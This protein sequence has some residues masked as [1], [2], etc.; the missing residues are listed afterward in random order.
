MDSESKLC[1]FVVDDDS[2]A[3]HSLALALSERGYSVELFA[4]ASELLA[5]LEPNA[6]GCLVLDVKM[7]GLSG[8]ELQQTLRERA[9]GLPIVFVTGH[10]DIAMSVRAMR[11]GALDFIEKPFAIEQLV[12]Q[13]ESAFTR[14]RDR[15]ALV[16]RF[17]RLTGRE[18]DVMRAL[19]AGPED[20]S[21]KEL[22]RALGISHRTVEH[23]RASVMAK[24]GARSRAELIELV[25]RS[26]HGV[27]SP[28]LREKND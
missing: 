4:S 1:V 21:A 3:R 28:A 9:I 22:A 26:E 25:R 14:E 17:D 15:V 24:T 6:S 12:E 13:I 10:G 23:H 8:L 18:R 7:P 27:V 16:A 20:A 2:A 11:A 5:E 19:V